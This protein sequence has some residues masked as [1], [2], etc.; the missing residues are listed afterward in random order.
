MRSNESQTD[1][2]TIPDALFA[3]F[4]IFT[5]DYRSNQRPPSE[6]SVSGEQWIGLWGTDPLLLVINR[7]TS[8]RNP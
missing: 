4:G 6:V 2:G 5:V 7:S 1:F 8:R 3:L